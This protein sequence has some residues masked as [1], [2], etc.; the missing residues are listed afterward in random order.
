M[1]TIIAAL[2]FSITARAQNNPLPLPSAWEGEI[3][4]QKNFTVAFQFMMEN[5]TT[6]KAVMHSPGEGMFGIACKNVVQ[7][8]DSLFAEVPSL[9]G[10]LEVRRSADGQTLTGRWKQ[11]SVI[12]P[13]SLQPAPLH[14]LYGKEKF[15]TP[16]PPFDYAA[17]DVLYSNADSSVTL[18]ATL[19]IPNGKGPF[20]AV[21]L[22]TGSGQQD[23]DETIMGHKP[24]AVIANQLTKQ[25]FIV[26][27][28][29]DRGAG[30]S[31]GDLKKATSA[32]FAK[33]VETSLNFLLKRKEVDIKKVGLIGHSE[34]G[35]I[36]PMVA[37]KRKEIS[38]IVLLA[39]PA[40]AISDLMADQNGAILG[41]S[42][43][44]PESVTS[45]M[46]F[47]KA[48]TGAVVTA[49]TDS[50]AQEAGVAAFKKWQQTEKP[51]IVSSLTGVPESNKPEAFVK[52]FV[53]QLRVAWW[54]FF[55]QYNPQPVLAQLSCKVLALNGGEDIQVMPKSIEVMQAALAKSKSKVYTAK[56]LPGLNHLFQQCHY[57]VTGEYAQLKESFSPQAL[58]LISDWLKKEVQ[59][60]R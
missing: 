9:K 44:A 59:G 6:L 47:Y 23:R 28:V 20:P 39:G 60:G 54:R 37:V 55:L 30:K 46:Q 31:K 29:D 1:K 5:D 21:I 18:G 38:F 34:G 40:Y 2:L 58:T 4:S 24:F 25:G 52:A 13:I 26:M 49:A 48:L 17:E 57:C 16:Q 3:P 11:G 50:L 56:V 33:D 22:I 42:G 27:R 36:A 53:G 7:K 10:K 15:Q 19:T 51:A 45:Y 14:Q 41:K 32:D 12:V 35:M 43:Y 8:G